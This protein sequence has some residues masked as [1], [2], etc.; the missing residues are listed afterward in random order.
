MSSIESCSWCQNTCDS[1]REC[2]GRSSEGV[3]WGPLFAAPIRRITVTR[4]DVSL[5]ANNTGGRRRR[6]SLPFVSRAARCVTLAAS[7]LTAE[8]QGA[9]EAASLK[10][11]K[12]P[13]AQG[14]LQFYSSCNWVVADVYNW[15]GY[16]CCVIC[17]WHS[18]PGTLPPILTSP[19]LPVFFPS[20]TW[21]KT[22]RIIH[23][24]AV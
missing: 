15:F 24:E 8:L 7:W 19:R 22:W 1:D 14:L 21:R 4:A 13:Q 10:C 20:E 5:A 2:V 23:E 6:V 9:P 11:I 16:W 12:G 3:G 17:G 18:V